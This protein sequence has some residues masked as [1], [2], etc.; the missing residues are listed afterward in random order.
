MAY[1]EPGIGQ[2][3]KADEKVKAA[4]TERIIFPNPHLDGVGS[5]I[6]FTIYTGIPSGK[7]PQ[8]GTELVFGGGG[9]GVFVAPDSS[10][11][12]TLPPKGA[13]RKPLSPPVYMA[14]CTQAHSLESPGVDGNGNW[15]SGVLDS[16]EAA[17][18]VAAGHEHTVDRV[19]QIIGP[20]GVA[21]D[22]C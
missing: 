19:E 22:H 18:G 14:V 7:P 9:G 8:G 17:F 12:V 4:E 6:T 10:T 20:V 5:G 11:Q 3:V 13:T 16:C 15:N 1:E 21:I 2:K